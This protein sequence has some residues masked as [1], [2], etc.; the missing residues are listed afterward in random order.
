[1][2]KRKEKQAQDAEKRKDWAW[3]MKQKLNET[4]EKNERL[5]KR[6]LMLKMRAKHRKGEK[7]F[8][9]SGQK[10]SQEASGIII[11]QNNQIFN[12]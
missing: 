9:S 5:M 6:D 8:E 11:F 2:V 12:L 3:N 4:K 10:L 7:A 1:M